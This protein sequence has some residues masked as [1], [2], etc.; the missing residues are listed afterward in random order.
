MCNTMKPIFT[1]ILFSF[2]TISSQ[3]QFKY[4]ITGGMNISKF[5]MS[6]D[7]FDGYVDKIRP[8]L[9]IGPTVVYT[10]PKIGLGFDVSAYFDRRVAK[11]KTLDSK[12]IYCN[13]FQFPVNVRYGINW[14]DMVY[15]FIFTGPQFGVNVGKKERIIAEGTGATTGHAMER[16]WVNNST[17]FSLNFGI[18]AVLLENAQI[19]ISYNLA[20][21]KTGVLQQIDLI[22]NSSRMLSDCKAN[23]WQISLSYLF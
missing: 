19:S 12:S 16:H 3:A 14:E 6:N 11:S 2:I 13:S 10:H 23:A 15:A 1:V 4:G 8:G 21:R 9:L 7:D 17:N 22:D 18:G 5:N 20:L